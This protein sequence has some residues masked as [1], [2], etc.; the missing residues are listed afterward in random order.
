MKVFFD[1]NVYVA[2][3]LNGR[4]AC[5]VLDAT[6]ESRWRIYATQHVLDELDRVLREYIG[7]GPRSVAMARTRVLARSSMVNVAPSRHVVPGDPADDSILRAAL[8]A[9]VDYLVTRDS[10]LLSL[11][12]YEKLRVVS[13]ASYYQLLEENGM[14]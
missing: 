11:D 7:L 2:E 3:A 14:I 9:G 13:L 8:I 5:T 4:A 1:T 6:V 12:P 10:H